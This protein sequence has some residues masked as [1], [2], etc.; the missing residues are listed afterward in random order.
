[1]LDLKM[2]LDF[3]KA[4]GANDARENFKRFIVMKSRQPKTC[5]HLSTKAVGRKSSFNLPGNRN[6]GC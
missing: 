2:L 4:L 1:M 3:E 5:P 6:R